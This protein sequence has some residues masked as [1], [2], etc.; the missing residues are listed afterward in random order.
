MKRFALVLILA[1]AAFGY[2]RL[3][4]SLSDGTSNAIQRTDVSALQYYINEQIAPGL[5]SSL[6]GKAVTV[7]SS[8]SSPVAAIRSAAATWNS[9]PNT[10][11]H[12][13]ALK[14]TSKVIDPADGQNTI[15]VATTAG[16]L[17]TLNGAIA[18]TPT[19]VVP[20]TG[21]LDSDI[22][23][24]PAIAFSTDGST[25]ADL[26]GV[27]THEF[28]H[29]LGLSHSGLLGAVMFQSS[30]QCFGA[31]CVA[32]L[33]QRYLSADE[34]AFASSVYPS[35][36]TSLAT[37]TGKIVASDGSPVQSVSSL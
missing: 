23:L 32:A 3:H 27:L 10:T 29:A 21:A 7:I 24:N 35:G 16:D 30:E 19:M 26:Q 12:F 14:T 20:S 6:S 34:M 18:I 31:Q 22:I 2:I 11:V 4:L 8:G 17:S 25:G 9:A 15:A 13:N 28:G 36:N 33:G 37:I 1:P 5:T